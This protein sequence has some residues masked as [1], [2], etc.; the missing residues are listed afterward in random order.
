MESKSVLYKT[1]TLQDTDGSVYIESGARL[2]ARDQAET[3][4]GSEE[5]SLA[6]LANC[7]RPTGGRGVW[8]G[9][10]G[11]SMLTARV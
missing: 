6:W 4:H 9:A 2:S 3:K 5:D 11:W 8:Q 1:N 10:S 7:K